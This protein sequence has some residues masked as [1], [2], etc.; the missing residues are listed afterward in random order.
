MN[1]KR[2]HVLILMLAMTALS[3]RPVSSRTN[4]PIPWSEIGAKVGADYPGERLAMSPAEGGARLRCVFQRL[5]GDAMRE[6]LWLS[7]TVANT[8]TECFRVVATAI[9]RSSG[10]A[11]VQDAAAPARA[12]PDTGTVLVAGKLV[13]FIRPGLIEE[14]SVS[15]EGVRQDFVVTQRP[16]G[17]GE[18]RLQLDVSGAKVQSTAYGVQLVLPRSKREIAYGRLRVTD[19]MGRELPVRIDVEHGA[20]CP[21][22][23]VLVNDADAMYPVRIDPTF[24]DANWSAMGSGINDVVYTLAVSG[25]D[26][27]AGGH[28]T[29]AGEIAATNIA[30]WNGNSWSALGPGMNGHVTALAVSGDELFAGGDFTAVGTDAIS[31]IARWNGSSWSGLGGMNDYVLALRVSGNSLHAGGSFTMAG[32][33]EAYRIAKWNGSGCSALGAGIGGR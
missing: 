1:F 23:A 27:Y 20:I 24:S 14:Y 9:G 4:A 17:A 15:T 25:N 31:T 33:I 11:A 6:G 18:L 13:R 28:F 29:T 3:V 12:L 16:E 5:E 32:G 30:K 21:T 19:A 8:M 26:L 7:S 22:L 10:Y 2:L